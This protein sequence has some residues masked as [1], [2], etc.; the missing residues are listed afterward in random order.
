M[1]SGKDS[2]A[3][4]GISGRYP[5]CGNMEELQKALFAGQDLVTDNHNRWSFESLGTSPRLGLVKDFEHFDADFFGMNPR[6]ANINDPRLRKLLEVT[7]EALMDAGLNPR[8]LRGSNTG[9]FLGISQNLYSDLGFKGGIVQR[10]AAIVANMVSYMFDFRG[11]SYALDTAC[12]SGLYALNQAVDNILSG[13]CSM[14]IVCV[15]QSQYDPAESVEMLR[16]GVLHLEG[17]CRFFDLNRKGYVKSEAVVAVVLQK[18]EECKRIYAMISGCGTNVNGF[19]KEGLNHPSQAAIKAMFEAVFNRFNIDPLAVNYVEAHGTG[20]AVGDLEEAE[21]IDEYLCQNRSR[22]FPLLIGSVKSNLGHSE[23]ASSLVSISKVIIAIREG[24]IPGNLH[25][26]NP[27]PKIKGIHEGRLKVMDHHKPIPQGLIMVN[28]FGFGGANG[29]VVLK[30][31]P[32]KRKLVNSLCYRLVNVSGRTEEGVKLMLEKT[33]ENKANAEFL[34]LIDNIYSRTIDADIYRGY[35]I[36]SDES[37]HH[38]QQCLS[39]TRPIWYVYSGIGSQ[40]LYMGRDLMKIEVFRYT[41]QKCSGAVRQY[42]VDLENIIDNGDE[43]TFKNLINTFTA[44]TAVS[45]CLTDVL[46]ALNIKPDG[47]IGHSLGEVACAYADGLIT[48]EQATLIAY[49][50]GYAMVNSNLEPGLM[51]AVGLSSEECSKLLPN[52]VYIACDNSDESVTIAGAV[53]PVKGFLEILTATGV[54][55]K[56]VETA[57]GAFHCPHMASA[58]PKMYSFVK[59]V[60]PGTKERTKRWLPSALPESEWKSELGRYN[61]AEYQHHNYINRVYF[62]QLLKHIPKDAILVEVAPKGLLQ[63]IL[64]RG[65]DKSVTLLPL[66]KP[67]VNNLDFFYSSIGELYINGGQP[68]LRKYYNFVNF[69]V[70]IDTPMISNLI[71]WDHGN[72]WDVPK[73][74]DESSFGYVFEIDMTDKKKKFLKGHVIDGNVIF[75]ATGYII[76]VWEAFAKMMGKHHLKLPVVFENVKIMRP[77][78][79]SKR[80]NVVLN[81]NVFKSSGYFE[82][83][84]V[85]EAVLLSAGRIHFVERIEDEF[86]DYSHLTPNNNSGAKISKDDFYQHMHLRGYSYDGL[87]LGVQSADLDSNCATLRWYDNWT[88]FMDVMVHYV[89]GVETSGLCL[90]I[91]F[92]KIIVDP[93]TH[94]KIVDMD[95]DLTLIFNKYVKAVKCGGVEMRGIQGVTVKKHEATISPILGKYIFVS[96]IDTQKNLDPFFHSLNIAHQ[97]VVENCTEKLEMKFAEL[98][99]DAAIQLLMQIMERVSFKRTSFHK[100]D[101]LGDGNEDYFDLLIAHAL[102]NE[103]LKTAHKLTEKAK[104]VLVKVENTNIP[105]VEIVYKHIHEN[106]NFVLFR[107]PKNICEQHAIISANNLNFFWLKELQQAIEQYTSPHSR[108]YLINEDFDSGIVGLFQSVRHEKACP[109]LRIFLMRGFI[110]NMPFSVKSEFY[111]N[112]LRKDLTVNV[113]QDESWGNYRFLPLE[114]F[115]LKLLTDVCLV[116]DNVNLKWVEKTPY[117][118]DKNIFVHCTSINQRDLLTVAGKIGSYANC[119]FLGIEYSGTDGSGE[120]I[121]GLVTSGA[122]ST[123]IIPHPQLTWKFDSKFSFEEAATIPLAYTLSYYGLFVKGNLQPTD[124]ILIHNF[125]NSVSLATLV[126]TSFKNYVTYVVIDCCD[127]QYLKNKFST[128]LKDNLIVHSKDAPFFEIV[129]KKTGGRGVDA[130]INC[131]SVELIKLSKKC[132][133]K[134]GR[135]I[136][137]EKSTIEVFWDAVKDENCS[138]H[139][140]KFIDLL[141]ET[142]DV[143][144]SIANSVNKYVSEGTVI[145]LEYSVFNK[146]DVSLA[147]KYCEDSGNKEKSI[148]RIRENEGFFYKPDN[149]VL[150]FPRTYMDPRK[151]YIIIGGLGGFG[152]E[153]ANWMIERGATKIIL[154]SRRGVVTG[155]QAL[156]LQR[157]NQQGVSVLSDTSDTTSMKG[158]EYLLRFAC[159][160]AP[161]GGIFNSGLRLIDK[162]MMEQ[163]Q[164]TFSTVVGPKFWSAQNMDILS[165]KYCKQ[166]EHFVLFSS[167][168]SS[169]GNASQTSYSFANNAMER[170]CERRKA[171]GL[172]ALAVQWGPIGDVG[173]VARLKTKAK[174]LEALPQSITSCLEILDQFMQ[175]NE[176]VVWALVYGDERDE[177]NGKKS[178]TES[179]ANLFGIRD[180]D[181]IDEAKTLLDLGMDSLL[182]FEIK[183]LL[184]EEYN[185]EMDVSEIRNITWAK[186]KNMPSALLK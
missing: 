149:R 14:A 9:V 16:F 182:A 3:I 38:V 116:K 54:F 120:N 159:N 112:Q 42:G 34:A 140:V 83:C 23:T 33:I 114:Q 154:N 131:N 24:I 167:I 49:A 53:Q 157:W 67:G 65:L 183:H 41:M 181:S 168:I 55:N 46:T 100:L 12:S 62:R 18:C 91:K 146:Y 71:R 11:P 171:E 124:R 155:Y 10:S 61:S 122:A 36:L 82:I 130:I 25:Y 119:D 39:K 152:L 51:A 105:D 166:L 59:S 118:T 123:T 88:S 180:V 144:T 107:A 2:I 77:I 126:L 178:V 172:P 47:I 185:L 43:K 153:L 15:A 98:G 31:Y 106:E 72:R 177:M 127:S 147:F 108:I 29:T 95:V 94:L 92:D 96:E 156:C 184:F 97:I 13:R 136:E 162:L 81:V 135:F 138:L 35:A 117:S 110:K 85:K 104:F 44:I 52:N 139:N 68:N 26:K 164:E 134:K 63:A 6:E 174:V 111:Q 101:S 161:V 176:P 84:E 158:A 113:Y 58:G 20:T 160:L 86:L 78:L 8:E 32:E 66:A 137:F 129:M 109:N 163:N 19:T 40:W 90:P 148:I 141:T 45:V 145:P 121:M 73:Y 7:F 37:H 99:V 103:E 169:L 74:N 22:N 17:V 179:V 133:S 4:S 170:L 151:C 102:S 28:A 142:E 143:L 175:Q 89:L 87:F 79:L 69:P 132:L 165:R 56:V 76:L 115:Q 50:R 48:A 93:R 70:S 30:P 125:T 128:V 57:G 186:I 173:F 64:K 27:D 60:L 1:N 75:P 150:A 21:I 5:S 80:S